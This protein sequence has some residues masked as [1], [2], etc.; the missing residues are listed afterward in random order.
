MRPWEWR[1]TDRQTQTDFIICPMLYD[2]AMGQIIIDFQYGGRPPSWIRCTHARDHQ[3][4]GIVGLYHCAKFGL[5]RLSSFD[6]IEVW[7]FL[8]FGWKLPIHAP[9]L[10]VLGAYFSPNDVSNCPNPQNDRPCVKTRRLSHETWKSAQRFDMYAGSRKKQD[11]QKVTKGLYFT[12]L[13]RRPRWTDF[14]QNFHGVWYPRQNHVWQVSYLNSHW[15]R[16]YRGSNFPFSYWF[17][18]GPY[19][20]AAQRR[21]LWFLGPRTK[22]D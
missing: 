22:S 2:I 10:G 17:L 5:N 15:L 3:Q 1:H 14:N 7:K 12:Y 19:N 11:S 8:R 9:I 6:N 16:F 21:C 20:S 18:H 13:G 4:S